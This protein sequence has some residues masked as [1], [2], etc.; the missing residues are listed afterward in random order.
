MTRLAALHARITGDSSDFVAAAQAAE[1]AADKASDAMGAAGAK[2]GLGGAASNLR[3]VLGKLAS[4]HRA[5]AVPIQLSQV[6]QQAAAGTP[7]LRALAIQAA[8][9]GLL[10]GPMGVAIGTVATFA[11]PMLLTALQDPSDEADATEEALEG[12]RSALGRV[13][14]ATDIATQDIEV[15]RAKY[16]QFAE[17]VQATSRIVAQNAMADAMRSFADVT[18]DLDAPLRDV[19]SALAEF[20]R[21][22]ENFNTV[23]ATLGERTLSN[24]SAFD[25]AEKSVD[26]ARDALIDAAAKLGLTASEAVRLNQMLEDMGRAEG[27][28][29]AA[30]MAGLILE[31]FQKMITTGEKIPD[32][33]SPLIDVLREVQT[34]AALA[35]KQMEDLSA[36][37]PGAPGMNTG[38]VGALLGLDPESLLPPEREEEGTG[39]GRGGGSR[40]DPQAELKRKLE[41]AQQLLQTELEAEQKANEARLEVLRQAK[42][43]EL[44]TE[45]E[46]NEL[47][48]REN[49]RH[50]DAMA[51]IDVYQ[52]G[53]R[54]QQMGQFMGDMAT[55][56][57]SGNEEMMRIS[58]VFGAGEAL[59]NAWRTFSQV[60][61]DPKLDWY[62]KI[63]A[64]VSLFGSAMQAV[65][66]IQ[67]VG[68]GGSGQR[69]AGGGGAAAAGGAAGGGGVASVGGP[70][71]SLTLIVLPRCLMPLAYTQRQ[72]CQ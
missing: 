59:I 49:K 9:I 33:L 60:M 36:A 71:V 35:A 28:E 15:L 68:K 45:A 34:E 32:A 27:P 19:M 69:S 10:F 64:A 56:F 65:N 6:A 25:E 41:Q 2:K 55:A 62:Q 48:E 70:A 67:S 58:K 46:F 14:T 5:K 30:R 11:I 31:E 21:E 51:G 20:Q 72:E 16:G 38:N 61:A 8:D 63:P 29:E 50:A 37:T 44:L 57:A 53:S 47:K 7:A 13:G 4:D 12:F 17:T 42:E 18:A 52:Y 26:A 39:R 1:S 23:A 3:G 40:R 22:T 66:A 24:A 43:A 54:A